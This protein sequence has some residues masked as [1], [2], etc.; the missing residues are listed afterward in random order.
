MRCGST[1]GERGTIPG[2][3]EEDERAGP[4]AAG[5]ER[6]AA[7]EASAE[8][9]GHRLAHEQQRECG[10]A[11]GRGLVRAVGAVGPLL[12]RVRLQPRL[13]VPWG[14]AGRGAAAASGIIDKMDTEA[15]QS[16]AYRGAALLGADGEAEGDE[17]D[18][19]DG[20]QHRGGAGHGGS[21]SGK[22][23]RLWVCPCWSPGFRMRERVLS[24]ARERKESWHRCHK[25]YMA[26]SMIFFCHV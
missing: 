17:V 26:W 2:G 21:V 3:E 4:G 5:A 18:E 11:H 14:T 23:E 1:G 20:G 13:R 15:S 10:A 8:D 22:A 7:A 19:E 16:R 25:N 12:A 9:G 6:G 24:R